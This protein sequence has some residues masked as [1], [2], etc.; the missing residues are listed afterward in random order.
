MISEILVAIFLIFNPMMITIHPQSD[1]FNTSSVEELESFLQWS[2][3]NDIMYDYNLYNCVNFSSDLVSEL[4][5]YGFEASNVVMHK[6]N[7]T[8]ITDD[9][10]MIV[11]VKLDDKIVFVEPQS[12]TILSYNELEQYYSE[13]RFTDIIIYNLLGDWIILSFNGWMPNDL[14]ETFEV[15]L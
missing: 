4:K 11:A 6:E 1:A 3:V 13:N 8:K 12:D 15:E 10:H 5:Y 2:S 9:R 7:G 14:K